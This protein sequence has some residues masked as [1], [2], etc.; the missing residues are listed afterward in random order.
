[1]YFKK[2]EVFFKA[3]V[4]YRYNSNI[5]NRSIRKEDFVGNLKTKTLEADL[6][7]L[8]Q[9]KLPSKI[10]DIY[11]IDVKIDIKK[12][13]HGSISVFFGAIIQGVQLIASYKSFIDSVYLIKEHAQ[14]LIEQLMK[15]K[16]GNDFSVGVDIKYPRF[17]KHYLEDLLYEKKGRKLFPLESFGENRCNRDAFFLVFINNEYNFKWSNWSYVI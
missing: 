3:K 16:Y 13:E 7:S 10:K 2:N 14:E 6:I 9:E 15:E 12:V 4:D 11:N 8:I 1:M 5:P 17:E